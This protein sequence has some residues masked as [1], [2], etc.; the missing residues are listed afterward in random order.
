MLTPVALT[1]LRVVL[2]FVMAVH[3]WLKLADFDAWESS[4]AQLGVPAPTFFA[5]LSTA[6]ELAGGVGLVVGFLTPIAAFGVL[7]NMLVGIFLVHRENG[8]LVQ[9]GGFEY[10]L[11]LAA[12]ALFFL[13]R[14]A[15]PVSV[16]RAFFGYRAE[17]HGRAPRPRLR[18]EAPA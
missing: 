4:L 15:G 10:P 8:F 6:A 14:G 2:G 3:G 18:H 17:E 1:I 12:L 9:N 13:V 16:D 7:L 5:A 11:I